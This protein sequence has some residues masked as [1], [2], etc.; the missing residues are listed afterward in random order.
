MSFQVKIDSD[1]Y[2]DAMLRLCSASSIV[3]A[4]TTLVDQENDQAANHVFSNALFG[5]W[6]LIED[7]TKRL[8]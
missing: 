8:G 2:D 1:K 3:S 4:L 6:M 7:A 5:A